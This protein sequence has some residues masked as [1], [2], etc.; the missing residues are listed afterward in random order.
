MTNI[1]KSKINIITRL[2]D[3]NN[4]E[5]N[6]KYTLFNNESSNILYYSENPLLD[7]S[8]DIKKLNYFKFDK[9]YSSNYPINLIYQE[10]IKDKINDL[11]YRKILVFSFLDL[12]FD[13]KVIYVEEVL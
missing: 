2:R 8:E 10:I 1:F 5:K 12:H 3:S 4:S 9:V 11:F 13:V 6:Y 7:T